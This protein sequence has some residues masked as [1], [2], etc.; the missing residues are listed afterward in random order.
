[1]RKRLHDF[2]PDT[3]DRLFAGALIPASLVVKAQKFRSWFRTRVLEIFETVDVII[4]PSTPCRAPRSGQKTFVLDGIEL[5]VRANLG[6][7]TQPISFIGLPVCAVPI[8]TAGERLPIG[9]QLIGAPW[10]EDLVLRVAYELERQGV[11]TAPVAE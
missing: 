11:V 3:R 9:V 5:P 8:W 4:A 10:R 1:L 2:D 6:I 7:Y